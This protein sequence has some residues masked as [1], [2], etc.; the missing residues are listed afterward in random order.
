MRYSVLAALVFCIACGRGKH[1]T[2]G[3]FT[4]AT[5]DTAVAD[6]QAAIE[7]PA[8]DTT[9]CTE[10]QALN[11]INQLPEIVMQQQYLDSLTNHKK[12]V[13]YMINSKTIDGKDCYEISAGYNGELRWENY[14]IFYVDKQDCTQISVIEPIEGDIIPVE[15]WHKKQQQL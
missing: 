10:Q 12:G 4:P 5:T 13:A 6:V 2:A 14:Y 8:S 11:A 7:Q 3:N 1:T 9:A 15:E